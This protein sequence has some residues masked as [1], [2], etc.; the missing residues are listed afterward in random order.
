MSDDTPFKQGDKVKHKGA[1]REHP[2]KVYEVLAVHDRVHL[3]LKGPTGYPFT[4]L[5]GAY[6]KVVPFFE[7]GKA[8]TRVAVWSITAQKGYVPE[9]F[10]CAQVERNGTNGTLVAFGQVQS[11]GVDRWIILNE[12][13][14]RE[15]GWEE[16]K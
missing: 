5:A 15:R 2:A 6:E 12:Y 3:W 7:P 11:D 13:D 10:E 1:A 14:F 4:G 8:Y 16:A 9:R